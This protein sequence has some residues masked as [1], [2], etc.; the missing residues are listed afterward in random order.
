MSWTFGAQNPFKFD[1]IQCAE[2]TLLSTKIAGFSILEGLVTVLLTVVVLAVFVP[3]YFNF[4][5][6]RTHA[7]ETIT[8]RIMDSMLPFQERF[9]EANDHYAHGSYHRATNDFSLTQQISWEPSV[10]DSNT[11]VSH[12]IGKNVYKV[13]AIAKDG[14]RL[15]R[16][17]PAKQPCLALEAHLPHVP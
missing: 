11:Y 7:W 16:L 17:Y 4:E 5:Q 2:L 12:M 8:Y 3:I 9:R 14:E 15:C 1:A 13:I 10:T 6:A